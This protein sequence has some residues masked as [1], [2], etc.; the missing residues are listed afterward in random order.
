MS[1]KIF[2]TD[3]LMSST[4]KKH[5]PCST[6]VSETARSQLKPSQESTEDDP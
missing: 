5:F 2:F 1:V 3:D 4:Y 6:L